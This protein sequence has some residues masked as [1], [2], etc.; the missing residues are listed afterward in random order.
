MDR[1]TAS[2]S[3]DSVSLS[4]PNCRSGSSNRNRPASRTS[5]D[6]STSPASPAR[7]SSPAQTRSAAA[8]SKPPANTDVR[9]HR[10]RSAGLHSAKLQSMA[11]SSV[12]CRGSPP[13][14]TVPGSRKQSSN[15]DSSS[16]S[17]STR[18][19][20]AASSIASGMPA[21]SRHTCATCSWFS[22][23]TAN[24]GS[25][26]AARSANSVNAG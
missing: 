11:A 14:F 16:A 7:T 22:A 8:R 10:S 9:A 6:F 21:S 2:A 13:R 1:R 25:T 5:T 15:P 23:V 12:W 18:S 3:P 17:V 24:P 4:R 26:A 19:R 20:T